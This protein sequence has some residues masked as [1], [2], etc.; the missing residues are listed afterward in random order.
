[1]K[2]KLGIIILLILNQ[3][4]FATVQTIN[5][6]VEN[7][8]CAMCPITV[9]KA[10]TNLAGVIQAE[11]AFKNKSAH[12]TYDDTKISVKDLISATT[13]A[14]YTSTQIRKSD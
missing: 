7:M 13:N 10:L 11:I 5:L 3:N 12:I 8:T 2:Y 9:K 6:A 1:M 4:S 14:G